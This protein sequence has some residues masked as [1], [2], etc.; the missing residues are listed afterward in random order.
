MIVKQSG[1]GKEIYGNS[2]YM[3][4]QNQR[5]GIRVKYKEDV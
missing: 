5:N 3:Y 2:T 4:K 1:L